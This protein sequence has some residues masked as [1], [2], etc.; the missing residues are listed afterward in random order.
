MSLGVPLLAGAFAPDPDR[1]R[2]SPITVGG[3]QAGKPPADLSIPESYRGVRP[4]VPTGLPFN[5]RKIDN[6][7]RKK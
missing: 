3:A 7:N 6:Q 5:N 1:N 2:S 4:A